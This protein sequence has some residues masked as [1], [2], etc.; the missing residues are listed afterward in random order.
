MKIITFFLSWLLVMTMC[1]SCDKNE[2]DENVV[3]ITIEKPSDNTKI[4]DASKVEI[5]ILF[6]AEEQIHKFHVLVT[7]VSD[8]AQ[9]ILNYEQLAHSTNL[10]YVETLDLSSFPAN[11]QFRLTVEACG[12]HDCNGTYEKTITFSI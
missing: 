2:S 10:Q 12:D 9:K 5:S 1:I 6:T 8:P 7:P 3:T 11:A 4:D